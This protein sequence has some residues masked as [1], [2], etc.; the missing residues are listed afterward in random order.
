MAQSFT[1][2]FHAFQD[3]VEAEQ[4]LRE[5]IRNIVKEIEQCYR[6]IL[7]V[8]QGIHQEKGLKEIVPIC[9]KAREMFVNVEKHYANL[10]NCVAGQYYRFHDHW[11]FVSQRL[12]FLA[13]LIVYLESETLLPREEAAKFL[14]V[15]VFQSDGFHVDLDDFLMG[16]LLLADELSRLAVNCVTWGDY[17]RPVHIAQ[18]ITELNAG[19]RLLNLKNDMLRKK[20]DA[21]KYDL[22]K[23][24]EVV[25][26]LSIRGLKPSADGSNELSKKNVE[27]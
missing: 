11:R 25:Y 9:K 24:E 26:D 14:G 3:Y 7:N 19:F 8:L 2:I 17:A 10:A 16:L 22:K 1:E 4:E 15:K 18:F 23:C 20:Y 5:E 6:E 27:V 12:V 21:L 13:A